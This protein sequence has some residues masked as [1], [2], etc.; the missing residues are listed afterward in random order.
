MSSYSTYF[1]SAVFALSQSWSLEIIQT[2]D[3]I[4][5]IKSQV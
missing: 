1:D 3:D 2:S 5:G 4:S